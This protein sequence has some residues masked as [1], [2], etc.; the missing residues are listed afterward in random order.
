MVSEPDDGSGLGL[1]GCVRVRLG[2]GWF[3]CK[4]W[5]DHHVSVPL[6][7]PNIAVIS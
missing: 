3:E 7:P 4:S 1:S 6:A 2:H 5:Q